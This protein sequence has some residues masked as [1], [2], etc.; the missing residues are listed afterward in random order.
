MPRGHIAFVSTMEGAPWGGSE[1]L[2]SRTAL[3][4]AA[5]GFSV[6][7]SVHEWSPPHKRVLA[8]VEGG[9]DVWVRPSRYSIWKHAW[10]RVSSTEEALMVTDLRKR[11]FAKAPSLVVLSTGT[12]LPPIELVELCISEKAPFVTI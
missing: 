12:A 1:E 2:W 6:W 11:I 8:L 9:V 7:A 4:L 5:Q 3:N 10:H